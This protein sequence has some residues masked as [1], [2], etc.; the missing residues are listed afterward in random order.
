MPTA[1]ARNGD[2][3]DTTYLD[4]EVAAGRL[5]LHRDFA[6]HNFRWS[7]V[8]KFLSEKSRYKTWH[9]LDAGCGRRVHLAR[10]LFHN[11][12]THTTGSYTGVDY[13]PV[14]W[15]DT[16]NPD[17][18]KFN[19]RLYEHTNFAEFDPQD[20]LPN[21][22]KGWNLITSFECLEHMQP[23]NSYLCLKRARE[24]V[25]DDGYAIISTPNY[26]EK[27]GA[28]ENHINEMTYQGL[29]ALILAAGW[30]VERAYGTF[31][32]QT[33]YK[34]SLSEEDRGF[35][36]RL[37]EYYDSTA[38]SLIMAPLIPPEQ[39]R[40]VMW[41]LRP[42]E[43]SRAGIDVKSILQPYQSNSPKWAAAVRKIRKEV[44]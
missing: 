2:D 18:K 44:K 36:D 11:M 31:A 34:K 8:A 32:S 37:S 17:T 3:F 4:P 21:K 10:L 14:P 40:N 1:S 23:Y 35:F 25:I 19:M 39:A 20:A 42:S 15:P 24:L 5:V 22:G 29:E 6:A 16:I 7:F 13:G 33:D 41:V 9:V 27:V 38:I 12:K 30:T 28:A 43:P 26:S